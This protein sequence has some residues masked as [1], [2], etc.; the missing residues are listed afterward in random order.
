MTAT[1]TY[2]KAPGV[3][4]GLTGLSISDGARWPGETTVGD[5]GGARTRTVRSLHLS[6]GTASTHLLRQRRTGFTTWAARD[7]LNGLDRPAAF[8]R[9]RA[10]IICAH[11]LWTDTVDLVSA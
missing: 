10:E 5:D 7:S 2:H 4:S 9:R 11:T 1:K 3:F 8:S 6:N